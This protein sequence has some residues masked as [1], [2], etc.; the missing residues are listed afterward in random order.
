MSVV[1][2][3]EEAEAAGDLETKV[4]GQPEQQSGK[5]GGKKEGKS[6]LIYILLLCLSELIFL[7][8]LF[9]FLT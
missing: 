2:A 9:L 5:K 8:F 4:Q 1:P 7:K 6:N 3:T